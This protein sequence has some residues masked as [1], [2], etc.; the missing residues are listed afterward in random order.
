MVWGIILLVIILT[1]I[2]MYIEAIWVKV[3]RVNLSKTGKGLKVIQ[4]SDIH[5]EMLRISAKKI[6]EIIRSENPDLLMLTGDYVEKP[7]N[8]SQFLDFLQQIKLSGKTYLCLGNHDHNAY[9]GNRT[10]L[11]NLVRQ[12]ETMQVDVLRNNSVQFEKDSK[13]YNIIGFD[14]LRSGQPD[15]HGAIENCH[16]TGVNIGI[17]HNP[18]LSLLLA[19]GQ[20]DCLFCGHFHGGQIWMPFNLEFILL[21]KDELCR[22]GFKKGLHDINGTIVYMNRGLGT[23]VFPFRFLSR[24]EVTVAI[25]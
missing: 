17:T 7:I 10:G 19:P 16:P 1:L 3:D 4:L 22:K 14:D 2:Y 23:V 13:I 25:I 8:A 24:P 11:E 12:I 20:V 21:R 5:V 9:K 15:I 6:R 18:D